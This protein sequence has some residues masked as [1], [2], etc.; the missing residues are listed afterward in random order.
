MMVRLLIDI[1][2]EIPDFRKAKGKRHPLSAILAMACVAM[3]CGCK[4]YSAM[5]E[6]GYNYGQKLSK[7][8]GFT[9]EKTPCAAILHTIFKNIGKQEFEAKV[10]FWAEGVMSEASEDET[11]GI[12]LDGKTLRGSQKQGA[13]GAHLLSAV[14]HGLGLTLTQRSGDH[15]TNELRIIHEALQ[16]LVLES[17]VFT[18]DALNT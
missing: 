1:L 2:A 17:R 9:H 11:G 8:L 14:S 13:P 6:W 3:M 15:S 7:A 4:S 10:G 16:D 12:S 18:M 5:A